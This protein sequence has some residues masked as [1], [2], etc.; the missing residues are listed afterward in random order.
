M[1][2]SRAD[3][4]VKIWRTLPISN[5]KPDVLNVNAYSKFGENPLLFTQ[6]IV[7]KRKYGRVSGRKL[8]QNWQNL[9]I[10]NS[11]PD[12]YNINAHTKFGENPLLFT[13]V[14]VR[15]ENMGVSPSDNSV[16]N[17]RILPI[18]NPKPDLYNINA[19]TKFGEN[20][21]MFTQ[22]IIRKR[23]TD[24]RSDGRTTDGRPDRQTDGLTDDQ[25]ETIIPRHYCVAGYKKKKK[26]KKKKK[27]LSVWLSACRVLI[28]VLFAL[29]ASFFLWC[30]G[31][32]VLGNCIDSWSFP[33][34]PFR[35]PLSPLLCFITVFLIIMRFTDEVEDLYPN[36]TYVCNLELHQNKGDFAH[37]K[38]V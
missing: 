29:S 28:V 35:S 9:P 7:Q 22:V 8:R 2:V 4:S 17:W 1:G 14:I 38:L 20:P 11:K 21:L 10:S 16:K 26:K 30:L 6:V 27:T 5:P 37:I 36:R 25:R 3:N 32:K 12:L 34:F 24:G 31:R 18:S 19:H 15:N 13:Q 33:S 23:K